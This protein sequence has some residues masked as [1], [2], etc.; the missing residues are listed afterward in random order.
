MKRSLTLAPRINAESNIDRKTTQRRSRRKYSR[1]KDAVTSFKKKGLFRAANDGG[2]KNTLKTP[3][4]PR[5]TWG[6]RKSG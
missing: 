1:G 4:E 3:K 6:E 2:K 5:P